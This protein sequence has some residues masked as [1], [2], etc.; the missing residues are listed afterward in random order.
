VEIDKETSVD[1]KKNE[2]ESP[3]NN[4]SFELSIRIVTQ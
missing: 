3:S 1:S 4:H 2:S